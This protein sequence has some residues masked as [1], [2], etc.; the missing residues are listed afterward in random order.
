MADSLFDITT[1]QVQLPE[2]LDPSYMVDMNG[3]RFYGGTAMEAPVA[4]MQDASSEEPP[5]LVAY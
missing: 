4:F 3:L 5:P 1:F 2:T